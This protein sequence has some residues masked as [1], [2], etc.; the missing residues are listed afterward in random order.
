MHPIYISVCRVQED[1]APVPAQVPST[2]SPST[3]ATRTA[4]VTPTEPATTAERP[5][6]TSYWTPS[7]KNV[8]V[9]TDAPETPEPCSGSTPTQRAPDSFQQAQ[10]SSST[11]GQATD[12]EPEQRYQRSPP[13][14]RVNVSQVRPSR[15]SRSVRNVWNGGGSS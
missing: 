13:T 9:K 3:Q 5:R 12:N 15:V 8:E 1:N 2:P 7:A 10:A 14:N 6:I 4:Q 11:P